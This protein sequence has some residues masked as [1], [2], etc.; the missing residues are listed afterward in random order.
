[1]DADGSRQVPLCQ[2][3]MPLRGTTKDLGVRVQSLEFR[4]RGS[5]LEGGIAGLLYTSEE[6]ISYRG[7]NPL[8]KQVALP[9]LRSFSFTF[10]L[11]HATVA[12]FIISFLS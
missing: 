9:L 7:C 6:A 12:T 1:M 3:C 2:D 8:L 5:E 4:A 10:V 11:T